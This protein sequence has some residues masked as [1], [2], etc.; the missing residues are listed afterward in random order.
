MIPSTD[1]NNNL[2]IAIAECRK[3]ETAS[4]CYERYITRQKQAIGQIQPE[5]RLMKAKP[6]RK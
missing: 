4:T 3:L 6:E 2:V 1:D 5:T